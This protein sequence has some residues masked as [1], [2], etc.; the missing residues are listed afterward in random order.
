MAHMRSRKRFVSECLRC[1]K[2]QL[3]GSLSFVHTPYGYLYQAILFTL[4]PLFFEDNLETKEKREWCEEYHP[5]KS[6][7]E[8][9]RIAGW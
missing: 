6:S 3:I 4:V 5:G 9:S 8:C 7:T 2:N 1:T